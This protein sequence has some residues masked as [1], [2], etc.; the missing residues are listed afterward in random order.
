MELPAASAPVRCGRDTAL[1]ATQLE[2]RPWDT[3]ARHCC[4][5]RDLFPC[6]ASR[7]GW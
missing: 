2:R 7:A 1:T 6:R 4:D 3:S 5:P